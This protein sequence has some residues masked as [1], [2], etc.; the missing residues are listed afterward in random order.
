MFL[1]LKNWLKT[2]TLDQLRQ[3][4]TWTS[5][6]RFLTPA[7]SL[8][9]QHLKKFLRFFLLFWIVFEWFGNTL[10]STTHKREFQAYCIKFLMKSLKDASSRSTFPICLMEM[11]KSVFKTCK[12]QSNAVKNGRRSMREHLLW[13]IENAR[14]T[15]PREL[16]ISIIIRSLLKWKHLFSDAQS[17]LR[18]V[19]DSFNSQ[20]KERIIRFLNLVAQ[21]DL[22]LR[23][24][25]RK[26]RKAS[27]NTSIKS[28][29][30]IRI[31]S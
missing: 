11:L 31:K 28:E 21:L 7:D 23:I 27:R 6:T 29:Q 8:R 1:V 30:L 13:S 14:K 12:I 22:K 2:S 26:S 17:S 18:F 25:L 19:R 20:E 9:K 10:N 16:G 3:R 5:W 24:F 4:T 15:L